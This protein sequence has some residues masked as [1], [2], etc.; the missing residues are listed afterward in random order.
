MTRRVV[1]EPQKHSFGWR[2][3]R[4]GA[5]KELDHCSWK[6]DFLLLERELR[7]WKERK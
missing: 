7:I 2:G 4:E 1:S 3:Y 5:K 6:P